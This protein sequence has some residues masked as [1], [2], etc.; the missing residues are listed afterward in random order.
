M[1]LEQVSISE[2]QS[3]LFLLT[4]C[5]FQRKKKQVKALLCN[6]GTVGMAR[7][8]I[9]IQGAWKSTDKRIRT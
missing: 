1:T 8:R 4:S 9:K 6:V 2:T 3:V 5:Y 7:A